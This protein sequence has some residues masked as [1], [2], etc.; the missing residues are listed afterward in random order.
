MRFCLQWCVCVLGLAAFDVS[1]WRGLGWVHSAMITLCVCVCIGSPCSESTYWGTKLFSQ[2]N[3]EQTGKALSSHYVDR[4]EK[5]KEGFCFA[6]LNH[7]THFWYGFFLLR[8]ILCCVQ[9]TSVVSVE[10]GVSGPWVGGEQY[11]QNRLGTDT[12]LGINS[13][14]RAAWKQWCSPFT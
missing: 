8:C 9:E 3:C 7:T 5:D 10:C 11:Q 12:T 13:H 6:T 14:T 4:K 1:G 2:Q